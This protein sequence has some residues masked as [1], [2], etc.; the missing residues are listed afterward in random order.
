MSSSDN[1]FINPKSQTLNPKQ[2]QMSK[3]Q[4]PKQYDRGTN[5]ELENLRWELESK[6]IEGRSV[7]VVFSL[8]VQSVLV[9]RNWD[10]G[11][12]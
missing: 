10:L 2:I 12:V 4:N 7:L 5:Q 8:K 9:I 6:N 1:K 3:A 11:F